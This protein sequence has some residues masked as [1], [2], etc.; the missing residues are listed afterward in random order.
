MKEFQVH[1]I[2]KKLRVCFNVLQ[3]THGEDKF[4]E[5]IDKYSLL[6]I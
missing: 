6:D 1:E 4:R 5:Y 2:I 3:E